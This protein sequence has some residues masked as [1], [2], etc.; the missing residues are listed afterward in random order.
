MRVHAA[1]DGKILL[2][3]YAHHPA[4]LAASLDYLR[5]LYPEHRLHVIFQP[6]RYARLKKYFADFVQVL[7]NK[8]D[9]VMVVPV[10][11]AWNEF[12]TPGAEDLAEA[13]S[14]G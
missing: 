3:D 12:G 5:E 9:R 8:A 11:A 14:N 2:E 1:N 13:L 4:E 7:E 6:H 10:F